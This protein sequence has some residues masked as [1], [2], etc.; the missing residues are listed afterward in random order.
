[1]TDSA[2]G[3]SPP[4]AAVLFK[5]WLGF[6]LP[7]D[8]CIRCCA[9]NSICL[10][11]SDMLDQLLVTILHPFGGIEALVDTNLQRTM[12]GDSLTEACA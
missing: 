11:V 5:C 4:R 6:L 8:A 3:C 9:K 1:M 10:S 7:A 2:A 12:P